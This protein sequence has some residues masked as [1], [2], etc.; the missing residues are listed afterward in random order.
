MRN[1]IVKGVGLEWIVCR[2]SIGLINLEIKIYVMA[3]NE[4]QE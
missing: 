3:I 4:K 2:K 1:H